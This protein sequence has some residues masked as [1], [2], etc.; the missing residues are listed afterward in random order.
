MG[1]A[2]KMSQ[3]SFVSKATLEGRTEEG[4]ARRLRCLTID[5]GRSMKLA[6][7]PVCYKDEVV[8]YV[9]SAAYGYSMSKLIAYAYLPGNVSQGGAVEIGYFGRRIQ[10]TVS[11][12]ALYDPKM[13]RLRG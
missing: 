13:T 12:E 7:E 3:D 8:G 2:V 1:F 4:S 5:D 10:A 11:A 9:T 6:K